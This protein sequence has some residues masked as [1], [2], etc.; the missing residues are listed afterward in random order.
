[1]TDRLHCA[2]KG[3]ARFELQIIF[4]FF[5]VATQLTGSFQWKSCWIRKFVSWTRQL[6]TLSSLIVALPTGQDS[7]RNST[8]S[9]RPLLRESAGTAS[10]WLSESESDNCQNITA[11]RGL[12]CQLKVDNCARG[13]LEY[14]QSGRCS[15]SPFRWLA[16]VPLSMGLQKNLKNLGLWQDHSLHYQVWWGGRD[17]G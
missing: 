5:F 11:A 13:P 1:M 10:Q 12:T 3:C 2:N 15:C 9:A 4:W 14:S 7:M 8:Q 17:S 16:S 6:F